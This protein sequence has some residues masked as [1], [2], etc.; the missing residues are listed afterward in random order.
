M[1]PTINEVSNL[2]PLL[3]KVSM[4]KPIEIDGHLSI[5]FEDG[6]L[7]V[8]GTD[9]TKDIRKTVAPWR[10]DQAPIRGNQGQRGLRGVRGMARKVRAE[11]RKRGWRVKG[12]IGFSM[13]GM[14]VQHLAVMDQNLAVPTAAVGCP[15]CLSTGAAQAVRHDVLHVRHRGDVITHVVPRYG[16]RWMGWYPSIVRYRHPYQRVEIGKADN[17]SLDLLSEHKLARY[18]TALEEA[19]T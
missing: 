10:L 12:R 14:I 7:A 3:V 13:G 17:V 15:R 8:A 18:G 1:T 19:R 9:D 2:W 11:V 16:F 6:I 5:G 4:E